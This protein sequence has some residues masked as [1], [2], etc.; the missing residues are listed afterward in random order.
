MQSR[1]SRYTFTL[2]AATLAVL[3]ACG[4]GGGEQKAADTE[5]AAPP[6]PPA[7]AGQL[8]PKEGRQV[9]KIEMVTDDQGN[10]RFVPAEITA[11][12]GDVLRYILVTGVHNVN[13]VADSNKAVT[14][15]PPAPMLQAPG[16]TFDVAVSW[17]AGRYYF[18]CD[19]H[20]LLGMIGYVTVK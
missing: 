3:T 18:Q 16:Q 1:T 14:M 5:A 12:E 17:P 7:A 20:A 9:I 19:P 4:G 13:F 6:P 2:A 8:T 15:P 11:E 10:N